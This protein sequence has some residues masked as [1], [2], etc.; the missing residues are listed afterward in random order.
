MSK[1]LLIVGT[2][3]PPIGG[4]SVHVSRLLAYL[5]YKK[6]PHTF[7]D[8]KKNKLK[9][10]FYFFNSN[11]LHVHANNPFLILFFLIL[12]CIF[13]KKIIITVH[14]EFLFEKNGNF[15]NFFEKLYVKF[16]DYPILLNQKD[17]DK[18]LILNKNALLISSFIIP[19]NEPVLNKNIIDSVNE[20]KHK[21]I[22]CTNAYRMNF[23]KSGQEIYGILELINFFNINPEFYFILSDPSGEYSNYFNT[24]NIKLNNNIL[25]I[26]SIHSFYRVLEISDCFIRNTI[27]DGDSLS[28]REALYLNKNVIATDCVPRPRSVILKKGSIDNTINAY[29]SFKQNIYN[30]QT[31][32]AGKI[33]D[34]YNLI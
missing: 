28:I 15:H 5:K 26:D 11:I 30:K 16:S 19:Y 17:V 9:F 29:M 3:P 4:V 10:L 21:S 2:V 25:I 6:Y 27:T 18:A 33:L 32:G 31:N 7:Y 13:S 12:S 24:K 34:L 8:Y 22:F 20:N 1:K 23:D 14:G